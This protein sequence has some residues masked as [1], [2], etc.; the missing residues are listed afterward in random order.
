MI[1][2]NKEWLNN[3]HIVDLLKADQQANR[4]TTAEFD[5]IKAAH[6]VGFYMPGA[7]V[8]V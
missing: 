2:Y 8:R 6:P 3:L 7:V 1:I 5:N 4:I